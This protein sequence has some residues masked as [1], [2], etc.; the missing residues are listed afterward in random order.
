M[1]WHLLEVAL[2]I[3]RLEAWIEL[4]HLHLGLRD[5]LPLLLLEVDSI[6]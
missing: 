4:P 3:D 1:I 5:E 6:V 2:E